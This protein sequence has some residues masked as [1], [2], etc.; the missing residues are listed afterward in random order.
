MNLLYAF[1]ETPLKKE[2]FEIKPY[3]WITLIEQK[4]FVNF[5]EKVGLHA[6][7]SDGKLSWCCSEWEKYRCA[8]DSTHAKKVKYLACGKRGLCPRCSMSYAQKRAGITYHWIKN[9]LADKLDFDLKIN[10][11]VLTLPEELHN[12]DSKE[13]AKMIK[14][15]MRKTGI[16]AYGYC[17]QSRHSS[18]PLSS[19]YKHCHILSLNIKQDL[20]PFGVPSGII[21]NGY[22]FD[23]KKMRKDW[24]KIIEEEQEI[25]IEGNVNLKTEYASVLNEPK[26]VMHLLKYVYRYPIEDLFNV[27]VRNK[28]LDYVQSKQIEKTSMVSNDILQFDLAHEID[29]MMREPKYRLV[30]CGLLTSAKRELLQNLMGVGESIWQNMVRIEKDMDIRSK[31]CLDCQCPMEEKPYDRGVYQGDNEP[32]EKDRF[33]IGEIRA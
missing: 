16:E 1:G 30:W 14:S 22:Y 27:Q 9:N 33:E 21:E 25:T 20:D 19:T 12:I 32:F 28:T 3:R 13:F 17:I 7:L 5:L 10:Q 29:N 23:V 8:S 24:K 4:E 31:Q 26:K 6:F 15:L 11:I 18:N 2:D